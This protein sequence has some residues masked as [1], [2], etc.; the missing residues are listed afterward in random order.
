MGSG[1]R[2][3]AA[4][5]GGNE[6]VHVNGRFNRENRVRLKVGEGNVER[7]KYTKAKGAQNKD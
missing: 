1:N 3:I 4:K 7:T 2:D 6:K 5:W